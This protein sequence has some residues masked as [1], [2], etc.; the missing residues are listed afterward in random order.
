[1]TAG[2]KSL[3]RTVVLVVVA[4]IAATAA[5]WVSAIYVGFREC[6]AENVDRPS[7]YP[8]A[9]RREFCHGGSD[10]ELL[11]MLA[12]PTVLIVVGAILWRRGRG[13]LATAAFMLVF[14]TPVLPHVYV[15][16]L[17]VYD[18]EEYPILFAPFLRLATESTPPRVCYVY[19]IKRGPKATPI[20]DA[21]ERFCVDL[22]PDAEALALTP[23]YDEGHTPYTLEWL[24]K[25]MTERGLHAPVTDDPIEGVV[26][27]R[28]YMLPGR[29]AERDAT[30]VD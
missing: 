3:T 8:W 1:M 5:V 20:T 11:A 13:A 17:D 27:Q 15:A 30:L 14:A 21:T 7:S 19:G 25:K 23:E 12:L 6:L 28:V 10:V 22:R 18:P 24:G 4:S 9:P 29:E 16:S 2:G 26:I